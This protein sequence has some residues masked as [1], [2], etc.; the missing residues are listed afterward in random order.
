[1]SSQHPV[2]EQPGNA[3]GVKHGPESGE[4]QTDSGGPSSQMAFASATQLASQCGAPRPGCPG[5]SSSQQNG[6]MSHTAWQ[7]SSSLQLKPPVIGLASGSWHSKQS[8]VCLT[9]QSG[10]SQ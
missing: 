1:M 10:A 7:H 8:P 6:S 4:S 9:P 2:S 5:E 3:W